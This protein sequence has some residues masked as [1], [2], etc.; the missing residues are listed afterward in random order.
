MASHGQF[1]KTAVP[2]SWAIGSRGW[3]QELLDQLPP[4]VSSFALTANTACGRL[5][6]SWL[7]SMR[8]L[9][10]GCDQ[11]ADMCGCCRQR[12]RWTWNSFPSSSGPFSFYWSALC[13]GWAGESG[14]QGVY[15]CLVRT[16]GY[17]QRCLTLHCL[18][19]HVVSPGCHCWAAAVLVVTQHWRWRQH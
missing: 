8:R 4:A 7:H 1:S 16:G 6:P 5:L 18:P 11:P 15:S 14:W 10:W 17:S 9:G 19:W 13:E 3:C 2:G 12:Q